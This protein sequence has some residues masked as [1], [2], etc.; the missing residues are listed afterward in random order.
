MLYFTM[1]FINYQKDIYFNEGRIVFILLCVFFLIS[2]LFFLT[3][4][5]TALQFLFTHCYFYKILFC[6]DFFYSTVRVLSHYAHAKIHSSYVDS[7]YTGNE[8]RFYFKRYNYQNQ[9]G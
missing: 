8:M 1:R 6:T 2:S 7:L 5:K 3:Q 4:R 9:N